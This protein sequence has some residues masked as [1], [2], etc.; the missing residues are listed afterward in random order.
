[1]AKCQDPYYG[2][3]LRSSGR[4]YADMVGGSKT[5]NPEKIELP[6]NLVEC[7]KMKARVLPSFCGTHPNCKGCVK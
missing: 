4:K 3:F 6:N 1:M 2:R 5:A 7:K